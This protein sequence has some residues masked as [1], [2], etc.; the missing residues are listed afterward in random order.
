M[1]HTS[2]VSTPLGDMLAMA[3]AR[4]LCLL[5]FVDTR[6]LP[7][8]IAQVQQARGSTQRAQE[9]EALLERT[10]QQLHEY[11]A[12]QRQHFD[13]PLDWVG[14]DFQQRVW[15]VLLTIP[16]GQTR[17]YAQQAAALGQANAVRAVAG[18]NGQNKISILVP[19][20]RV[21][22]SDGGLTGYSGGLQRKQF[23]LALEAGQ[24]PIYV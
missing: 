19:C 11:F 4:G 24:K 10:R 6:D 2:T 21:L 8:S 17:S 1:L 16:F 12:G 7:R 23:L 13:V 22:G 20:H 18:A 14:T 3:S 9:G 15:Q 5:E